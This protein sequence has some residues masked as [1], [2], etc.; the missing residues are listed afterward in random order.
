MPPA[1]LLPWRRRRPFTS[2]FG[3]I[4]GLLACL[5]LKE[6]SSDVDLALTDVEIA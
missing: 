4:A 6:R 1:A 5:I 3:A 2:C